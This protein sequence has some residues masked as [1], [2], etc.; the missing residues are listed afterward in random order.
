MLVKLWSKRL[1]KQ[2]IPQL[3]SAHNYT[4]NYLSIYKFLSLVQRQTVA[5]PLLSLPTSQSKAS[6][7]PRIMLDNLILSEKTW[8]VP[9]EELNSLIKNTEIDLTKLAA[10]QKLYHLDD[11]V[12]YA[13][14][15]NILQLNLQ[16]IVMLEILLAETSGQNLVELKEV[17]ISQYQ[18]PLQSS[19]GEWYANELIIPFFNAG[20]KPYQTFK[21]HQQE[22]I[23]A[24][25]LKRRFCPGSEWLSLKI[26]AGNS[27]VEA[28][29]TEKLLPLIE[30][31][32]GLFNKW[33]FIRYSDPDWHLRIRFH[34]EPEK[35]YRDLLP[36]LNHLL[37]P[38]V[39]SD[40]VQKI[41]LF[42]YEREIERYGGS[43]SMPLIESLF[44]VDSSLTIRTAQLLQDYDED[45]RWRTTLLMTD[46]LLNL[47]KYSPQEKLNLISLLRAGLGKE[48]VTT[49]V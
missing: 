21:D 39:E 6:F 33:F 10:L 24:K 28:I 25:P 32:K 7:V 13:V 36:L 35:L 1:E 2:I 15:D 5:P 9:R 16:N 20:A 30:S 8:R 11:I 44:M 41:E 43:A 47:F 22:Y 37:D 34:G 18:T 3:S 46:E 12:S 45:I 23:E 38:L 17:L 4:S 42:T 31:S 40:E 48:F 14:H 49:I 29:L 27:S 19:N 26:Y